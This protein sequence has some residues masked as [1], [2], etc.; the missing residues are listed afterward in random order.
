[1]QEYLPNFLKADAEARE[2]TIDHEAYIRHKRSMAMRWFRYYRKSKD[3]KKKMKL[4]DQYNK[5]AMMKQRS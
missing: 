1:M 2:S 3:E 4:I 5:I